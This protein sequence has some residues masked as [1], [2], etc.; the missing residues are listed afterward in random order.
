MLLVPLR[1]LG[2]RLIGVIYVEPPNTPTRA[3]AAECA[4]PEA[5]ARQAALALENARLAT[6]TARLLAKEQLLADLGRDV[7]NTLDFDTI[8]ARTIERMKIAFPSGSVSLLNEQNELE[9]V[10]TTGWLDE[11]ARH[12]RVKVGEGISGWV[13]QQGLP[14]LS[15]DIDAETRVRLWARNVGTN[16][17]DPRL[18]RRAAAQRR[19]GDRHAERRVSSA[20]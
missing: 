11:A 5:I 20:Q 19:Q 7:S 14:Y 13:I 2:G 16:K 8:L 12:V 17:P 6:R 9:M 3:G 4:D 18:Y 1:G 10:A 15:N